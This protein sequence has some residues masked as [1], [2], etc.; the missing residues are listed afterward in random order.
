MNEWYRK[1]TMDDPP[2]R[3]VQMLAPLL[4][5]VTVDDLIAAIPKCEHGLIDAHQ[6]W[7]TETDE[8]GRK[9]QEVDWCEGAL[10]GT[11]E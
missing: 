11:D 6:V 2:D 5:P 10:G 3:V 4:V 8:G 7:V 1:A 9:F